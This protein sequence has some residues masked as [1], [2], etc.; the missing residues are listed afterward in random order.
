MKKRVFIIIFVLLFLTGCDM[1][2]KIIINKDLSSS[3]KV[4]FFVSENVVDEMKN[5]YS[6]EYIKENIIL[7]KAA[8]EKSGYDFLYK[9][10]NDIEIVASKENKTI[11]FNDDLMNQNYNFYNFSCNSENC[12]LYAIAND[13][14]QSDDG[15]VYKLNFS[16]QVPYKVLENNADKVDKASN[17]YTWYSKP[18]NDNTDIILIFK[19]EGANIILINKIFYFIKL[20][21]F[22]IISL[23]IIFAI[24]KLLIRLNRNS[25][26]LL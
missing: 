19:K 1:N 17:T 9:Y 24:I 5:K 22:A 10:K 4:N 26:P 7:F 2:Y 13:N 6:D 11:T 25:K 20:G 14:I 16:I 23:I 12:I 15:M 3:E 8:S 18:G 21:I